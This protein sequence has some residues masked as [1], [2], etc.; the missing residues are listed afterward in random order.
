M[1]NYRDR[2]LDLLYSKV[3]NKVAKEIG[4]AKV[5]DYPIKM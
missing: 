4:V 1:I 3:I 5:S 2:Y